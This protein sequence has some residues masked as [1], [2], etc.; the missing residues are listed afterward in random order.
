M[1][2][3]RKNRPADFWAKVDRQGPDECWPWM[4]ERF[5]QRGDYGRFTM[6]GKLR[7][8][9]RLAWALDRGQPFPIPSVII[10]HTCDNPPCCN[11]RHLLDGTLKDNTRDMIER[12]RRFVPDVRGE[13]HGNSKLTEQDVREIRQ[14]RAAGVFID[15]ITQRFGICQASV[16]Q[17]ANGVSWKHVTGTEDRS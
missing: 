2:Q 1:S 13:R 12:G 10:R 6:G 9:H 8:A 14:L 16:S 5:G 3:G 11:P 17:I 15:D 4:G 7:Q